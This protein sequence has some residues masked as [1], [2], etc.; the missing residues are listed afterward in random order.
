M[1]RSR[2][3]RSQD[4]L[5]LNWSWWQPEDFGPWDNE[6][7]GLTD[8]ADEIVLAMRRADRRGD[9]LRVKRLYH[10]WCFNQ[11]EREI[12]RQL[13]ERWGA[14]PDGTDLADEHE[15]LG[16]A[17]SYWMA[18]LLDYRASL[19]GEPTVMTWRAAS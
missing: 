2:V 5:Y 15:R 1:T 16:T 6:D 8:I 14:T 11:Q 12:R 19:H 18:M 10:E 7:D 9:V 13:R 17:P 3:R 4:T